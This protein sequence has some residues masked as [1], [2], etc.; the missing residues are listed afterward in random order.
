VKK[1]DLI[2]KLE[3]MGYEVVSTKYEY[4]DVAGVVLKNKKILK[5]ASLI[6]KPNQLGVNENFNIEDVLDAIKLAERNE[7]YREDSRIYSMEDYYHRK[8]YG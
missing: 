8:M 1:T 2:N 7:E 5:L 3:N 4:W 6:R